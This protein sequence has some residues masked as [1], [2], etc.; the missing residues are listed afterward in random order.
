MVQKQQRCCSSLFLNSCFQELVGLVHLF[1]TCHH[2]HLNISLTS[3]RRNVNTNF[4]DQS[5]ARLGTCFSNLSLLADLDLGKY[6]L[7][8]FVF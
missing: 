4:I 2:F 8:G 6:S 1:C 5:R 3:L 7:Y